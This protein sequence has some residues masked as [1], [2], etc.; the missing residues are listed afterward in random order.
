MGLSSERHLGVAVGRETE[1]AVRLGDNHA[2]ELLLLQKLPHGLGHITVADDLVVVEH[3]AQLLHLVVHVSL[4]VRRQLDVVLGHQVLQRRR[5]FENITVEA[6]RTR[7]Q[8]G[9]LR[10]GDL[11]HDLLRQV[12]WG[13]ERGWGDE[14][15]WGGAGRRRNAVYTRTGGGNEIALLLGHRR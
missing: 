8:G 5:A 11:W 7:L 2:E 4:L 6:H 3:V 12:I 13:K 9:V 1:A 15:R 14:V 10:V